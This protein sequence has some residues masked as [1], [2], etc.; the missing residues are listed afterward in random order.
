MRRPITP[1]G[2]NALRSELKKLKAMRPD[3]AKAIATARAHG[4]LSENADYD[5]AKNRSG[6]IEAKI[7][8]I[9]I[10]LTNAD[11]I[12]PRNLEVGER[13]VFGVSV[14]IEDVE[15]GESRTL[16]IVGADESDIDR[17]WISCESPLG[18]SLIGRAIGETSRVNLP[19]GTREYEI[20]EVF[21]DYNYQED[22]S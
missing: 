17:G 7:R 12:D 20:I 8:D 22:E 21:V 4:D 9:E 15:S 19:N 3:L 10:K 13:V 18:R 16:S 1:R 14:K 6:M 5:A 2:Y 11:M